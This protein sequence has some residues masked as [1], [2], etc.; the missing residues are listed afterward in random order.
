MSHE[1]RT[2]L[3]A[4]IGFSEVLKQQMFGSLGN[5]CY[6][7]Y[8]NDIYQSG[9]HLLD[10]INDILDMSKIEAG[11]YDLRCEEVDLD[12]VVESSLRLVQLR[13]REAALTIDR[14]LGGEPLSLVADR[15]ALKQILVNLLSNAVK[16][17]PA[18]GRIT[19]AAETREDRVCL[20]V[21]DTGIGIPPEHLARL[22][23]PFE[24]V[25]PAAESQPQ[26]GTGLGLALVK[27]LVGLHGG[28]MHIDSAVGVGTVVHVELP[29]DGPTDIAAGAAARHEPMETAAPGQ[30]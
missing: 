3:N 22:G 29:L 15:R 9:T 28:L 16:F 11:K 13:A 6:V 14:M 5:S 12:E 17:T 27:A 20:R 1:L 30:G 10:L 2:P 4:I 26:A 18:G 24:Q 25:R 19:I 23:H 21:S 7:E 8:A